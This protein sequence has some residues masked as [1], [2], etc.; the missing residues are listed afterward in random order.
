[1][2]RKILKAT[3]S[4]NMFELRNIHAMKCNHH[5]FQKKRIKGLIKL[6]ALNVFIRFL[7]LLSMNLTC[8]LIQSLILLSKVSWNNELAFSIATCVCCSNYVKWDI[9]IFNVFIKVLLSV[10]KGEIM[11]HCSGHNND[12]GIR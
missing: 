2:K 3:C 4:L 5:K 11:Q 1:M 6:I 10:Y 9:F 8:N 7:I 12:E